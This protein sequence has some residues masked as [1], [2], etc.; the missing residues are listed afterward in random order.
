[1]IL[2]ND[3]S[4][5]LTS[6]HRELRD[7]F[8]RVISSG[9]CILG[10]ECELFEREFAAYCGVSHC[11][12]VGN[13]TDALELSLRALGVG[14]GQK[15]ATVANA[16]FYS[17]AAII[18]A[19][20]TPVFVDVDP[21]SRLMDLKSLSALVDQGGTA[22]II[23]THLFG[24]MQDMQL[25]R[26]ITDRAKVFIVEDC[27]QAHGARRDERRAGSCGDVGC[28]SFYPTKNLGAV[29]DAGAL[30]CGD[31]KLAAR[32][33]SLRQY[34]WKEKYFVDQRGGVNSRLDELQAAILRTKLLR[35]DEWNAR[36]RMVASRYSDRIRNGRITCPR[37]YGSE[38]VAHLYV[39]ECEDRDGLRSHLER[40]GIMTDVHY[41]VADHKQRALE[42]FSAVSLPVTERLTARLLTLPCFPEISDDEVDF[43]IDRVNAW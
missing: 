31:P 18:R 26:K 3:L 37:S 9:R 17:C 38:Y 22:A 13:G 32:I 6:N 35:L 28:F 2:I 8:E 42:D 41:P 25:I 36:R 11:I 40:H 24:L 10:P 39:V 29:G 5:H 15:V 7:A 4:R 16:G 20:A 33:R 12:G 34:G 21:T 30:V 23:V 43:V 19:G 14:S 1:M 27:A